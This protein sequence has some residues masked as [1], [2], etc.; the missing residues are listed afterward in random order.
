MEEV[1]LVGLDRDG[2]IIKD[3]GYLGKDDNWR[4]DFVIYPDAPIAIRNLKADQRSRVIVVS[5]QGGVARGLY[6]IDRV[7]EINR[8]VMDGLRADGVELDGWY[9]CPFIDENYI[10]NRGLKPTDYLQEWIGRGRKPDIDMLE[11]AARDLGATLDS[12]RGIYV[13][14]D[15]STD[16]QT[17]LN[18]NG[19]GILRL[20]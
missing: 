11:R 13:V 3:T 4:E 18:A 9:F 12:F 20:R 7:H 1:F 17:A 6:T 19:K 2:T 16:V 14:G 8:A 15:M 10:Q 5:N